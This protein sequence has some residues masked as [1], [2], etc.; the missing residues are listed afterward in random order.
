[1]QKVPFERPLQFADREFLT[2]TE[3][4]AMQKSSDERAKKNAAGEAEARGYRNFQLYTSAFTSGDPNDRVVMSRRTSAIIDPPGGKLPALT[5]QAIKR[6]EAQEAAQR[7]R[8]EAD[9]WVDRWYHERCIN[10]FFAPLVGNWGLSF[11]GRESELA[12]RTDIVI[13]GVAGSREASSGPPRRFLQTPGYVA[14][15]YEEETAAGVE[16]GT[17]RIIPLDRRPALSPKIRDWMGT[18]RG[19]WDGNTLVVEIKNLLY[20]DPILTTYGEKQRYP[21]TGETLTVTERYTPLDANTLEYR[22]TVEDPQVYTRP[23]TVLHELSR[24]DQFKVMPQLCQEN[25]WRN[26]GGILAQA[27]ADEESALEFAAESARARQ[28]RLEEVK[29]ETAAWQKSR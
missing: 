6:F 15:A 8:G 29:A 7:G 18:A 24:N 5:P 14:I 20:D 25:N 23:Y 13:T 9:S 12:A 10:A 22:Y 27:R 17:Y 28:K 1:M 2:D 3:V 21:G 11:G 4:A 16:S 19:H 26:M